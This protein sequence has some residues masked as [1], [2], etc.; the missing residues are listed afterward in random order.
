MHGCA[1]RGIELL[2]WEW[3][4][5]PNVA[6]V[7]LAPIKGRPKV[8]TADFSDLRQ[9][10]PDRSVDIIYATHSFE[11]SFDPDAPPASGAESSGWAEPPG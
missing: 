11:H 4:G 7:E 9:H 3:Q 6:G 8:L 2:V 10:F 1:K 5:F